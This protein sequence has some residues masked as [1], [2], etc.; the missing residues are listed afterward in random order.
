M[1]LF[2]FMRLASRQDWRDTVIGAALISYLA[3]LS[4]NHPWEHPSD[5]LDVLFAVVFCALVVQ[6][7]PL[8]L[9]AAAALAATNR[10]SAVFAGLLWMCVHGLN[11]DGRPRVSELGRGAFIG[12]AVYALV[13]ALRRWFAISSAPHMQTAAILDIPT[14]VSRFIQHPN[15]FDWPVLLSASAAPLLL[16]W[17]H[18]RERLNRDAKRLLWA[19]LAIAAITCVFGMLDE[20]RV[21]LP[22]FAVAAY[23]LLGI[24]A[25][26]P[27]QSNA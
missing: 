12:V 14:L 7:R 6:Q 23:A 8:A 3:V 15:P 24:P 19:S 16:L 2:G 10:E 9:A 17:H 22:C 27:S 26:N 20:V 4:F 18:H 13:L 25:E 1:M 5:F 11:E 21:F